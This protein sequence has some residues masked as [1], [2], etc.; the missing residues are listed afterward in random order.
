MYDRKPIRKWVGTGCLLF[1]TTVYGQDVQNSIS[2]HVYDKS[3]GQPI[4]DVN[5]YLS[6]STWGSSTNREGFYKIRQI[7]EGIHELV[8]TS[9]GYE[10]V[11][12]NILVKANSQLTFNFNLVP[13][14]YETEAT[15]IEG[16]VPDQ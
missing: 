2:G 16:S 12:K 14:I 13:V 8:V 9:V 1:L 15:L 5:V 3:S 10:Y 7:P 11:V 4:E 6:N